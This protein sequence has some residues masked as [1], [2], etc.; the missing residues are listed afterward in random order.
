MKLTSL[1][2]ATALLW[3]SH[4]P[5]SGQSVS[6]IT[7]TRQGISYAASSKTVTAAYTATREDHTILANAAS[8][9][10]TVSLPPVSTKA[11]PYLVIKKIDSTVN[12]VTVDAYGSQTVDGQ[13]S[14]TLAVQYAGVVLH[15]DGTEWRVIATMPVIELTENTTATNA[16]TA[17]ESGK[18]F[19]LNS[20]TEFVST[21]PA[22][23]AGLRYTFIVAAAP[24]GASYTVVTTSSANVIK[25]MQVCAADAAGDTGTADDTITFAD[26][27]AVAGDMV[28]VWSDGTSWFAVAHSRVAAGITFT[29][30]S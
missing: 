29:Q 27:Q 10:F 7:Q 12:A 5:A 24:S 23:A 26:G 11:Y 28:T 14:L 21:L 18:T 16:I 15:A 1:L 8:A 19:L 17:A 20:A 9:A 6:N 13:T 22:P 3:L 2:L 25:G 30:A 4:V